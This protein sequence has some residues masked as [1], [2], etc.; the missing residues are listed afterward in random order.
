MIEI[1]NSMKSTELSVTLETG[2]GHPDIVCYQKVHQSRR[3]LSQGRHSRRKTW[4]TT[5][6]GKGKKAVIE[7]YRSLTRP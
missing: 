4:K 7:I 1:T 2:S 3:K 6:G 5:T